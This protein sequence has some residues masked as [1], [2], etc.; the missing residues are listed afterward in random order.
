MKKKEL[1][2]EVEELE[3]RIAPTFTITPPGS[4]TNVHTVLPAN[5]PGDS[6][7]RN[8]TP[9]SADPDDNA[10]VGRAAWNAGDNTSDSSAVKH[11]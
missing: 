1:K 5:Q 11:S 8:G 6:P 3:E 9:G 4:D 2:L 10:G 7:P